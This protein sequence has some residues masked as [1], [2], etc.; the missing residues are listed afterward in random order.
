MRHKRWVL[1]ETDGRIHIVNC[2]CEDD[3]LREADWVTKTAFE[4][5]RLPGNNI[6][7][8]NPI[9]HTRAFIAA[10]VPGHR[11]MRIF[12]TSISALPADRTTRNLWG[13]E[14]GVIVEVR[15]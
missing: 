3:D 14:N 4:V 2:N 1:Q 10:G 13:W 15:S 7:T 6:E 5:S 12:E 9:I 11:P 8:Y